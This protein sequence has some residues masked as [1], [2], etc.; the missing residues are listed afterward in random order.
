MSF[1]QGYGPDYDATTFCDTAFCFSY[2]FFLCIPSAS[3]EAY[4]VRTGAHPARSEVRPAA[5]EVLLAPTEGRSPFEVLPTLFEVLPASSESRL[6]FLEVLPA[7]FEFHPA[8]SVARLA[9]SEAFQL[10]LRS[11][12]L[13]EGRSPRLK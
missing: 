8:P 1:G 3:T 11:F 5:F 10:P 6:A 2:Y 7:R 4:P 13:N 12:Q 9:F